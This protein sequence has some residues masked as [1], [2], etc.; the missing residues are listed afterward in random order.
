MQEFSFLTSVTG[1][2]RSD[3]EKDEVDNNDASSKSY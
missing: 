1:L 2:S 3:T